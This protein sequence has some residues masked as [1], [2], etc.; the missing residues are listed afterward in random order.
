MNSCLCA[1]VSSSIHLVYVKYFV[2]V[3]YILTV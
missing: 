2:W 1:Q 3:N